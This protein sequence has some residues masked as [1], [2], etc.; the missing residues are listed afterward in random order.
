MDWRRTKTPAHGQAARS[1]LSPLLFS[2]EMTCCGSK[3]DFCKKSGGLLFSAKVQNHPVPAKSAGTCAKFKKY[4][5]NKTRADMRIPSGLLF[6][7]G[8]F[9]TFR[10]RVSVATS[11]KNPIS[12]LQKWKKHFS[13]DQ[14]KIGLRGIPRHPK[15]HTC[16]I[17]P[18]SDKLC[19]AHDRI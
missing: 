2:E 19:H 3:N 11:Q 15:G 16:L 5:R 10:F 14:T 18:R 9:P 1:P 12:A 17:W 4:Y 8:V 7:W 13:W 6:M